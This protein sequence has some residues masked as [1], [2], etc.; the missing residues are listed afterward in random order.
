MR[1]VGMSLVGLA[2]IAMQAVADPGPPVLPQHLDGRRA[3]R[4]C[5]V[6]EPCGTP[7]DA[8]HAIDVELFP[9][10]DA[11]PWIGERK[12]RSEPRHRAVTR[13]SELRPDAAWLD[14]LALPDLPVH[15]SQRLVDY[16]VFYRTDPRGRNLIE[17]WFTAHGRYRDLIVAQ[18]RKAKLPQDLIY[19]SMIE[20]SYDPNTMS[21]AGALGLWQFMPEAGKIYGLRQDRWVDERRDPVRSTIAQMDYFHDLRQRFGDWDIALASFNAGYGAMLRSVA[22]FNTNDYYQLCEYENGLPWETCLYTPKF[23]AMAIIGRNR[24]VFGLDRIVPAAAER[25][26][27]VPV[28]GSMTLA[29]IARA[30]GTTDAEI[31][32]LNPHLRKNRTPPGEAGYIVR[33]PLGTKSTAQRQIA[34]SSSEWNQYDS[35]VVAR[36]ERLEDVATTF[37]ISTSALRKLNDISHESEV[38]GGCVLVVP[39][40]AADQ[41]ARNRDK[42]RADLHS[43]GVDQK[44]GEPLIVAIPDPGLV[45]PNK[46]RVFYRVVIGDSLG[47]IARALDVRT[48]D[49]ARWNALE[50]D[51]H[52]HPRMVLVAY[53]APELDL[54]AKRVAL[55]DESQLVVV[56]RGST[57]HLDLAEA[58]T[59]RVRTEYVAN[60]KESLSDIAKKYGMT[61]ADLARIN[62]IA[63]RTV[64][65]NGAT[66]VVYQVADPTRS[67]RAEKQWKKLPRARRK[68]SAQRSQSDG[69]S[70]AAKRDHSATRDGKR[71]ESAS[72]PV[73]RPR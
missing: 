6:D 51:A 3:V 40:I 16:L 62:R 9:P 53:I 50:P 31:K 46:R 7:S 1:V 21:H 72:G 68:A 23:L 20:S 34:E 17:G 4:G 54:A 37:G 49:L 12:P 36:G 67:E 57:E 25:W 28:P 64:P 38:N 48:Q 61:A 35:Y 5:P 60:G 13:P 44:R 27:E 29:S 59:G 70:S 33:V 58:R 43:S 66:I 71:V 32:R 52:I 15:W 24:S 41:R 73:T 56:E 18:L 14:Q 11:G 22:R 45:V 30:A 69:A 55:L 2:A 10:P 26:D 47:E 8:M 19:I 39:R 65:D 63:A 42:A